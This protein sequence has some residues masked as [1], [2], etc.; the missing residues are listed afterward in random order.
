M[1]SSQSSYEDRL[2]KFKAVD[3]LI[4]SWSD[5]N[6]GNQLI[7]KISSTS[8]ISAVETANARVTI[9]K[10]ELGEKIAERKKLCFTLRKPKAGGGI[11]NPDCA[12]ERL[13]R[14]HSYLLALLPKNSPAVDAL[15]TILKKIRPHYKSDTGKKSFSLKAGGNLTI[16]NVVSDKSAFNTGNSMLSWQEVKN[17]NPPVS[18]AAKTEIIIIVPSG[19]ILVKNL[20]ISRKGR[21]RLMIKAGKKLTNS[22]SEKTFVSITGFLNEVITLADGIADPPGYTPPDFKLSMSELI[23]LC[24]EI[25]NANDEVTAARETYSNA[26]SKRRKLYDG[27]EGM[28]D[29][30]RLTK[31]YLGSFSGGKKSD[32]FIE[33]SQAL[34][35]T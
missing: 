12:E 3:T 11:T 7:T 21:I 33:Y 13:V 24:N 30:I 8:L 25:Q 5:Y 18:F 4:Q 17:P 35:G 34:K 1:A 9:T 6:P 22:R 19:K 2:G 28:Q 16:N 15:A 14:M 31:N 27:D 26:N 20:S 29:R 10:N 23:N 32:H